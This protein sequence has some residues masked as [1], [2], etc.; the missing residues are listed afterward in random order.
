MSEPDLLVPFDHKASPSKTLAQRFHFIEICGGAGKI[1]KYVAELGWTVGPLIDLDSSPHFDWANI[2]VLEWIYHLLE[3]GLL[4]AFMVEPPCT[5]FSP[6]QYPASRSY[7]LPRGFNPSDP[8]TLL[9]TTLAC[10]SLAAIDKGSQVGAP[11][12]LEQPRRSKMRKLSE[13]QALLE[14]DR[15]DEV[16]TSSCA[17]GSPHLKEFVFLFCHMNAEKVHKP[18]S[19]DHI[20]VKIQGSYTKASATYVDGLAQELARIFSDAIS[21][22]LRREA[23]QSKALRVPFA[24]TFSSAPLGPVSLAGGGESQDTSI[25]TRC[26][27]P[28]SFSR[29]WPSGIKSRDK[30]SPWIPMFASLLSSKEGL[31]PEALGHL[32]GRLVPLRSQAVFTLRT[33]LPLLD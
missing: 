32:S 12:L 26:H 4:D 3:Q 18:C 33:I 10:R 9:G 29:S 21:A 22:K 1:S 19:K 11:S 16:W 20:H 31:P 2:R 25:S 15:A 14:L 24:M 8:K 7:Q 13:W 17:Y 27:P 28:W 5:T 23:A 6:A 30:C